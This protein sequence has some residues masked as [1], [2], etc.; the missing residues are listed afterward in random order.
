MGPEPL[1]GTVK[2]DHVFPMRSLDKGTEDEDIIHF[3]TQSTFG[4]KRYLGQPKL[5]GSALSLEYVAGNLHRAATRGSERGEDVTLNAKLVANVPKRLNLP[6]DCHVRG[7]VVMP[8]AT[9]EEKYREVSPNPRN[10]CSGALRQKH[11]D[12][13]QKP[14]ILCFGRTM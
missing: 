13:R 10:L 1:P 14:P 11:G 8:L 7:E 9:F 5:D 4:G 6:I 12:A 3:V 2:V